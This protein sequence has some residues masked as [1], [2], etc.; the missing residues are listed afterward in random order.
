MKHKYH[1]VIV[2]WSEGKQI[3]FHIYTEEDIRKDP[4]WVD[5]IGND[6]C[7]PP[8]HCQ[9]YKWR[10]KP[11]TQ[12]VWVKVFRVPESGQLDVLVA[13]SVEEKSRLNREFSAVICL[14]DWTLLEYEDK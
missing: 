8:F 6:D 7:T 2:A 11:E 10:V 12:K 3:Q 9:R 4:T 1:D 14:K 13:Y 5:Y